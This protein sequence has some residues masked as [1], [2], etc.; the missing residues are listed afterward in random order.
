MQKISKPVLD[1]VTEKSFDEGKTHKSIIMY[2]DQN[3]KL[4]HTGT[5]IYGRN[6]CGEK[7][8]Y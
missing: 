8:S 7:N 4:Q 1:L 2:K 3:P 5:N 6:K